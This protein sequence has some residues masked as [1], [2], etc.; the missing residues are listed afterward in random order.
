[1]PY[2]VSRVK[3]GKEDDRLLDYYN[4]SYINGWKGPRAYIAAQTPLATTKDNF[5]K[6]LLEH[7]C[8]IMINL[9]QSGKNMISLF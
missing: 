1:M 2:D 4:A 8:R 3:V 7:N 9:H 6:I 5:W